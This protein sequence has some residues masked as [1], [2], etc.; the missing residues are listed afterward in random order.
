MPSQVQVHSD[1]RLCAA[2]LFV[3]IIQVILLGW[4]VGVT[5][6]PVPEVLRS[7]LPRDSWISL[8]AL[9]F[10][11]LTVLVSMAVGCALGMYIGV[12]GLRRRNHDEGI[13]PVVRALAAFL[14]HVTPSTT[15]LCSSPCGTKWI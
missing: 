10:T 8:L 9:G 1:G 6:I 3:S 2:L 4:C 12:L 13:Q 15:V 5:G 14:K 11:T 7:S